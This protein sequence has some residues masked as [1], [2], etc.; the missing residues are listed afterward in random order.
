MGNSIRLSPNYG[1]NPTIPVCF[2][3]G[4]E[5]NEIALMG[6]I[7]DGR[8]HE[9]IQAPKN[10]VLDFEPCDECKQ[11]MNLGFTIMEATTEPNMRC[12]VEIQDGVYPTGRFVVMRSETAHKIFKGVSE[13]TEKCFLDAADFDQMFGSNISIEEDE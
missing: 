9:D 2:W 1:V 13:D 10:M 6:R 4:R 11:S 3:C 8:K 12:S 7:G 5:K